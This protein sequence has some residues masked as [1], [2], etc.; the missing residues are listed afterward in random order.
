MI[1]VFTTEETERHKKYA[2]KYSDQ[3]GII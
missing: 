3:D 1:A 2:K